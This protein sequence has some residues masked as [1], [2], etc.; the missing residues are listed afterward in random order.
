MVTTENNTTTVNKPSMLEKN[1][2]FTDKN[3]NALVNS[4]NYISDQF[5]SFG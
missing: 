5:D 1:A 3:I 2:I 4:A